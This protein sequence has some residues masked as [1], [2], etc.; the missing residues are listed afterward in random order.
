MMKTNISVIIPAFNE[1]RYLNKTIESILKWPISTEIVIIDDGSTDRTK[2]VI[3]K[4]EEYNEIKGIYINRNQGKGQALMAGIQQANGDIL[5]FLDADLGI[6][7]KYAVDLIYPVLNDGIDMTIAV[8]PQFTKKAGFGFVKALARKGIYY[9]T[10]T[11]ILAPLSGQ[12]AIKKEVIEQIPNFV[13]G[14]GIEVGLTIDV[15]RRGFRIKEVEIPL[16]HRETGRD[17]QGFIHR[18]KEFIHVSRALFIKW[19]QQ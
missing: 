18:G 3:K 7:A 19:R 10:R 2:E 17:L 13:D 5:V 8:F 14:F 11:N 9:L 4:L 12:R 16:N 6:S 15:L 1:D